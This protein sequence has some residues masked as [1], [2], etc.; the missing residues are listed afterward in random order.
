MQKL[1]S[2]DVLEWNV[3]DIS[4]D[5][6]TDHFVLKLSRPFVSDYEFTAFF[7]YTFCYTEYLN[8]IECLLRNS[9]SKVQTIPEYKDQA[10][11]ERE[12]IKSKLHN[13]FNTIWE[14]YYQWDKDNGNSMIPFYN[15]DI[16]YNMIKKTFLECR[17][18]YSAIVQIKMNDENT[19]FLK[20]YKEMMD[21]FFK[22]LKDS[23]DD[24]YKVNVPFS[25]AFSKC[26]FYVMVDELEKDRDS[27]IIIS[28]YICKKA[29]D[30][31]GNLK[32]SENPEG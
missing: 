12:K 21:K 7:K 3:D 27:R 11:K 18:S 26:P 19:V 29:F 22:Y 15:L 14:E 9:L 4:W 13:F 10:D 28:N 20:K 32:I 8:K 23:I 16:T 6:S 1:L 24:L 2:L 31:L 17:S 30:I 25:D 5:W